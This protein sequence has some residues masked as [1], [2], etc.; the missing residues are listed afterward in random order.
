[1]FTS[2]HSHMILLGSWGIDENV[3]REEDLRLK[4]SYRVLVCFLKFCELKVK[5]YVEVRY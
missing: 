4:V 5:G 3:L 2:P 1:M